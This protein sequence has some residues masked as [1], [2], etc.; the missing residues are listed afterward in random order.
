MPRVAAVSDLHGRLPR[1]L[2]GYPNVPDCDVLVIAGDICPDFH[3]AGSNRPQRPGSTALQH[4]YDKG[5][6]A[7]TNWLNTTFREWLMDVRRLGIHNIVSIAGNH[8]FVFERKVEPKDL[9]W[10][11]LWDSETAVEGLRFYGVPWCPKLSRWAF[12][13]D[14]RRLRLAYDAV[15]QGMDV[16]ISHSPPKGFGD[17]IPP[18]SK[19]NPDDHAIFV[20]TEVLTNRLPQKLPRA[21]VCGHIHE[22]RGRYEYGNGE[23]TIYNVAYLNEEYE[24]YPGPPCTILDV[25]DD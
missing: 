7:Q 1:D 16:L 18:H 10:T 20:G 25:L 19:F 13:G 9:P 23:T 14:E 8:D 11:Y 17:R 21:V 4:V 12:Y 22:G 2:G 6:A 5:E 15:P 3:G 24:P